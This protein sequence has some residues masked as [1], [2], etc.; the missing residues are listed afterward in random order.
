MLSLDEVLAKQTYN[1]Y[2]STFSYR[3]QSLTDQPSLLKRK[4]IKM[5]VIKKP[6]KIGYKKS[7]A[8][9]DHKHKV[10]Y[11]TYSNSFN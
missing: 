2:K 8:F 11:W 9:Y 3:R 4:R 10:Y 6:G 1:E 5:K 7:D